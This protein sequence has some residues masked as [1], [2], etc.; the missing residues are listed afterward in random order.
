MP[1]LENHNAI[2]IH[3]PKTGGTTVLRM[4]GLEACPKHIFFNN[5]AYEYD[6]A[7]AC[8]VKAAMPYRY[9]QCYKFTIVRNPYDRLLSEFAWK[10][11]D[12]DKRVFDVSST[13]FGDFVTRLHQNFDQVLGKPHRENSHF[14]PQNR[15][16]L[17]DVEVFNF[18]QINECFESLSKRFGV[19][20][21]TTKINQ[22]RHQP[23]ESYYDDYLKNMVYDMYYSDFKLFGYKK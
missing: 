2:F 5:D 18:E 4:F 15:F 10:K 3:I 1:V 8:I 9:K 14:I 11:Q 17:D 13:V 20:V 12:G 21:L 19:P 22:S 23:Y 16:V 7:S 6:H